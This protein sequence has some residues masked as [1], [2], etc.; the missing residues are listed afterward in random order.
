MLGGNID[1][2]QLLNKMT[3][4]SLWNSWEFGIAAARSLSKKR[5]RNPTK[6]RT[7]IEKPE[8]NFC[9]QINF[10]NAGVGNDP[11]EISL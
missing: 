2:R 11:A 10:D 4:S 7:D 3:S 5:Q 8:S 6:H 1:A 9:R